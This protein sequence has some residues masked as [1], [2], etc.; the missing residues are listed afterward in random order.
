M[1]GLEFQENDICKE[2]PDGVPTMDFSDG[3][4]VSLREV[5]PKL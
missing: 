4:M 3:F 1:K 5:W 2:S